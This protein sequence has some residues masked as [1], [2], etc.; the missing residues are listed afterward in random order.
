[1][2]MVGRFALT[3]LCALLAV[4]VA[5]AQ[6]EEEALTLNLSRDFGYGAG[7]QMQGRFSYRVEAPPDVIRVEFL[8]DGDV[9]GVD[10]ER[11]FRFAFSTGNHETS[12]H[13]LSAV[14]YTVDGRTLASN[15]LRRQFVPARNSAL[16]VGVILAIVAVVVIVRYLFTRGETE[17]GYGLMGGAICPNCGRPF[18][19]HIWSINLMAGRLD[20]CPHCGKWGFQRRAGASA[21]AK[22]ERAWDEEEGVQVDAP[23]QSE[24]ERLRRRL[25]DSRYE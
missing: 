25:D 5:N 17:G 18:P 1:M 7:L 20:R 13:T 4:A 15:E 19:L 11:P 22:A 21:L 23:G 12:W 10:E 2:R 6:D 16:Y 8:L 3:L 24:E 14:G 9:L